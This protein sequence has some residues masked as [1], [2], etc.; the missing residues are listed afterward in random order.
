M[1]DR[2]DEFCLG[3]AARRER[4]DGD[5]AVGAGY[6]E[7]G[8]SRIPVLIDHILPRRTGVRK[9]RPIQVLATG[10]ILNPI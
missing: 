2:F 10:I 4:S 1:S 5:E 6:S 9:W 8:T 7:C 3:V